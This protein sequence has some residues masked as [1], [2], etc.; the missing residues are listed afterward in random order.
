MNTDRE[1]LEYAAKAAGLTIL[2][3]DSLGNAYTKEEGWWG[4]LSG[5]DDNDAD[6]DAF[7]LAVK[8]QLFGNTALTFEF[9]EAGGDSDATSRVIVRAAAEIG[10]AMK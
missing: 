1:L 6:G 4:P 8:L 10:K 9:M 7:R 2:R 3:W 5:S